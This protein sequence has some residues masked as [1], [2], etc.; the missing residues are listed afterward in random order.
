MNTAVAKIYTPAMELQIAQASPV[1]A[2]KVE[3]L[4]AAFD[5]KPQSVIAKASRMAREG[6]TGPNGE[7]VVYVKKGRTT[8]SGEPVERKE[9]I[10]ADIA[11]LVGSTADA[12]ESLTGANM[13]V[14]RALRNALT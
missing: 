11:A 2:A 5:L 8:K 13:T 14:L 6:W 7:T 4:A 9:L 3:A 1:D 10:V 12:F